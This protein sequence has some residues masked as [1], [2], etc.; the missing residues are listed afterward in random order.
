[1]A[2]VVVVVFVSNKALS[3]FSYATRTKR[4]H[5]QMFDYLEF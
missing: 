3:E 5:L 4:G 2:V 1:V